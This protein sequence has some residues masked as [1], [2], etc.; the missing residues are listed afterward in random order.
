MA[1]VTALGATNQLTSQYNHAATLPGRGALGTDFNNL[2]FAL[3][4]LNIHSP[5]WKASAA[6]F[7]RPPLI[8][9]CRTG[10]VESGN[11]HQGDSQYRLEQSALNGRCSPRSAPDVDQKNRSDPFRRPHPFVRP[12]LLGFWRLKCRR[13]HPQTRQ[14]RPE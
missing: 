7:S 4:L 14:S 10:L 6:C 5:N 2:A 11:S 8:S 12:R 9:E 1:S 13:T 3:G